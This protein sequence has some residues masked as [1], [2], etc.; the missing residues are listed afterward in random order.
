MYILFDWSFINAFYIS[1]D[2]YIIY[3]DAATTYGNNIN[4]YKVFSIIKQ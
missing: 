3:Y 2:K 4:L 1:V